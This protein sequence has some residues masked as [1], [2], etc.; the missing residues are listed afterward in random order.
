MPPVNPLTDIRPI[1]A[2]CAATGRQGSSVV[3][4]L[5]SDGSFR[6]RGLTRNPGKP[7]ARCAFS[8]S[9]LRSLSAGKLPALIPTVSKALE[10]RGV[11]IFQ[12][13]FENFESLI[14]AFTG[15]FGVFA[16]TDCEQSICCMFCAQSADS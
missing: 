8:V 13:D 1:I 15:V 2:V 5:C 10:E 16:V 14:S 11:D 12:V 9:S 7:E 3:D 6:I 4:W